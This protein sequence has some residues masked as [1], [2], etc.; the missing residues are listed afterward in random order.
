M[1]IVSKEVFVKPKD[2][3]CNN[4]AGGYTERAF[5]HQTHLTE[6][7][8]KIKKCQITQ[9][10]RKR[11]PSEKDA[12]KRLPSTEG[13]VAILNENGEFCAVDNTCP[14]AMG[15]LGR[16][17]IRN[18]VAVCPVHGYA[19]DTKTGECQT[20]PRLRIRTYPVVVEDEEIKVEV[21]Q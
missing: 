1:R 21:K 8:G 10:S 20:D 19:Y 5:I 6:P 17:R 16:G 9:R 13:G 7:Q 18:G 14:H 4:G 12:E 3:A 15:S 2:V 11:Q